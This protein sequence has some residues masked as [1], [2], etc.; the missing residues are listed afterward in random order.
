MKNCSC[1]A[2]AVAPPANYNQATNCNLPEP[3]GLRTVVIPKNKGSDV[4]GQPFAPKLGAERNTIVVYAST[5]S[6]YLYDDKG[7]YTNLTG[8]SILPVIDELQKAVE[9]AVSNV[10]VMQNDLAQEKSD[11]IAGQET[12]RDLIVQ[13]QNGLS[14]EQSARASKDMS[15]EDALNNLKAEVNAIG[16][17]GSTEKEEREAADQNLQDQIDQLQTG[18]QDTLD[19]SNLKTVGGQTL[20]G[21]GDIPFPD[22]VTVLQTTGSSTTATMSQKAITD[23]LTS[24]TGGGLS[25]ASLS[26]SATDNELTL[27][28]QA[29]SADPEYS[30]VGLKTIAGQSIIGEGDIPVSGGS[31]LGYVGLYTYASQKITLPTFSGKVSVGNVS[32]TEAGD[33]L[34]LITL[35]GSL[36]DVVPYADFNAAVTPR[37]RVHI[38]ADFGSGTS[39]AASALGWGETPALAFPGSNGYS[40][41]FSPLTLP[42]HLTAAATVSLSLDSVILNTTGAS[43]SWSIIL[44]NVSIKLWRIG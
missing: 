20:L 42:F 43:L 13:L 19:A 16:G 38:Q 41:E 36:A 28:T 23:A 34:A 22:G 35:G 24:G 29:G 31:N 10:T 39:G 26:G 21:E 44:N 3:C 12:L 30:R 14:T 17:G 11:R 1:K 32:L 18:K 7:V 2:G 25:T 9:G 37:A 40:L 33:Y 6:V 5:G 4:A 15:L 8:T 27:T